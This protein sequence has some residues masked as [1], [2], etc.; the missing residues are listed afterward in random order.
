MKFISAQ[1]LSLFMAQICLAGNF[2]GGP[3]TDMAENIA[4]GAGA[5]RY[6]LRLT[7]IE[8][9]VST[10]NVLRQQELHIA[11]GAGVSL[12]SL[13]IYYSKKSMI[14]EKLAAAATEFERNI[15]E[16]Q[17]IEKA[18]GS[19]QAIAERAK[20]IDIKNMSVLK[21][22]QALEKLESEL[23]QFASQA[24]FK[25]V[26]SIA[27]EMA[28]IEQE[29][30]QLSKLIDLLSMKSEKRFNLVGN[31]DEKFLEGLS[32]VSEQMMRMSEALGGKVRF[33][34]MAK[35]ASAKASQYAYKTLEF[36]G[37][38][39]IPFAGAMVTIWDLGHVAGWAKEKMHEKALAK[40]PLSEN[41]RDEKIL[42]PM[43]NPVE[44][45]KPVMGTSKQVVLEAKINKLLNGLNVDQ[46]TQR[47]IKAEGLASPDAGYGIES[48]GY[49]GVQ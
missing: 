12:S 32:K 6:R 30:K 13:G 16:L 34:V 15:K 10:V 31:L 21:Q 23:G 19:A 14:Q 49:A 22:L 48:D 39:A 44:I 18:G 38:R 37:K 42:N 27:T 1:T 40:D 45:C 4:V 11:A 2:Y 25:K 17:A 36:A 9:C 46:Q 26:P 24:G 29:S 47:N 43:V 41:L 20:A 5:G 33:G 8:K 7:S 35:A 3:I 28:S